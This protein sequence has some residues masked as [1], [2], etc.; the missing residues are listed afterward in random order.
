MKFLKIKYIFF[1]NFWTIFT[2][3]KNK[4]LSEIYFSKTMKELNNNKPYSRDLLVYIFYISTNTSAFSSP[5][6]SPGSYKK[7]NKKT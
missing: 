5:L 6:H 7:N 4:T 1:C 3:T 2:K